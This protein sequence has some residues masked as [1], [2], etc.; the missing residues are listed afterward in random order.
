MKILTIM[1]SPR[2][3]G[4]SDLL[5]DAFLAGAGEGGAFREKI[6]VCDLK[7]SPCTECLACETTG[8]CV[9]GDDMG[10]VY[11]QLIEADRVVI[12]SPIFFYGLPGQL[13]ALIDRC[14]ALWYRNREE[15]DGTGERKRSGFA[16]LVG[17][18]RGKN[19][20]TGSL[21]TVRYFLDTLPAR[22][23]GSLVYREIEE[24]GAILSRPDA[25]EE[26]MKAG[27]TFAGGGG[28]RTSTGTSTIL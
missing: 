27:R 6:A 9:I 26:A 2:K 7:I 20:F 13:K 21:L 8:E 3:G 18:T 22:L 15:S 23:E 25:L 19:L 17:A 1:G 28:P 10:E 4:N 24:K 16:L 14:Q 12:A 11:R 5:L